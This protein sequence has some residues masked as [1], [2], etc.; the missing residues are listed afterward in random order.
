MY[1]AFCTPS[2]IQLQTDMVA[3]T[4]HHFC[5]SGISKEFFT[6][7][8]LFNNSYIVPTME[9]HSSVERSS[10]EEVDQ[11]WQSDMIEWLL[12]ETNW[13]YLMSIEYFALYMSPFRYSVACWSAST[14]QGSK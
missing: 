12:S 5:V 7:Q 14:F 11:I 8:T 4:L 2:K 13:G 6:I 1:V 3:A 9:W 10:A